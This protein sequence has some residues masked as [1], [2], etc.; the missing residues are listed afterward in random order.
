MG[1]T[2]FQIYSYHLDCL[3]DVEVAFIE[4][5]IGLKFKEVPDELGHMIFLYFSLSVL[6]CC[7]ADWIFILDYTG[8]VLEYFLLLLSGV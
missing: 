6:F 1:R 3:L 8:S 4:V 2:G 5:S 7:D